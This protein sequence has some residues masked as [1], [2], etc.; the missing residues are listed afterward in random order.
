MSGGC[1]RSVSELERA[2]RERTAQVEL[3]EEELKA[4]GYS[5]AHDLRAP[6]NHILGFTELLRGAVP[7]EGGE[8]IRHRAEVILEA[9]RELG[10]RLDALLEYS[11]L[12][13]MELQWTP[14]NLQQLIQKV[15]EDIMAGAQGR[16]IAWQ[17]GPVPE[18]EGDRALLRIAFSFLIANAVKFT[19]LR[20][21]AHISV[22]T[23]PSSRGKV[24]VAVRDNGVGFN[25]EYAHKLFGLF[26]RLHHQDEFE[27][28]GVSLAKVRRIIHRHGG[29]AWAQGVPGQGATFYISFPSPIGKGANG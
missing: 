7:S 16:S 17:V 23:V 19:R 12:G 13:R 26:R 10:E 14:V 28:Q 2:L 24:V 4:L 20:E 5:V 3:L 9:G 1:V 25:S 8:E 6:L 11:H 21:H 15:K 27:G 29:E 18:V 22:A